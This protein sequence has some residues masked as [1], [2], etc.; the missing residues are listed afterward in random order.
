MPADIDV[1]VGAEFTLRQRATP[2]SGYLWHVETL[3][4]GI[5]LVAIDVEREGDDVRPGDSIMQVFRFRART[6]GE[7]AVVLALKRGWERDAAELRVVKVKVS[8]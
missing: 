6:S 2:G 5:E 1:K 8:E 4:K 7:H 3:P